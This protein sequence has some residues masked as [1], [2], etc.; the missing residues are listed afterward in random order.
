LTRLDPDRSERLLVPTGAPVV[1][2]YNVELRDLSAFTGDQGAIH[3]RDGVAVIREW[4]VAGSDAHALK[5]P[6][7][8]RARGGCRDMLSAYY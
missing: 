4:Q 3:R 5:R 8:L 7:M 2:I 1:C 6:A